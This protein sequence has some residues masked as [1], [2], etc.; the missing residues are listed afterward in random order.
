MTKKNLNPLLSFYNGIKSY[1][2][3]VLAETKKVS[4]PTKEKTVNLTLIVIFS[5]IVIAIFI[6]AIDY[7]FSI[8]II[9]A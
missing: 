7:L 1:F 4:W 3:E 5:S 8:T 2:Q 6:T 9:G